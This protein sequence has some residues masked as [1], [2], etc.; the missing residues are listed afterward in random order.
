MAAIEGKSRLCLSRKGDVYEGGNRFLFKLG[1]DLTLESLISQGK[2]EYV[3]LNENNCLVALNEAD[4]TLK[5]T[6]MEIDPMTILGVVCGLV[7]YPHQLIAQEY[8]PMCME[9]SHWYYCL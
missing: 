2:I 8:L 4:I 7:P 6:H 1:A 5:H 3:E 9:A